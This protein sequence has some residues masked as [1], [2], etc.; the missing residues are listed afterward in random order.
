MGTVSAQITLA[1]NVFTQEQ[2]D[3][4][5]GPEKQEPCYRMPS[6]VLLRIHEE[7][8][9]RNINNYEN[10]TRKIVIGA[11]SKHYSDRNVEQLGMASLSA[12]R[13]P[14]VNQGV[15]ECRQRVA[16]CKTEVALSKERYYFSA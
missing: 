3:A 5:P 12:L 13:L 16:N 4:S 15:S 1:R 8:L 6:E 11:G 7:L 14:G 9:R 2:A 10:I